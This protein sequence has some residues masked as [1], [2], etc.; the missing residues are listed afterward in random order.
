VAAALEMNKIAETLQQPSSSQ[1]VVD[2]LKA[3]FNDTQK[4]YEEFRDKAIGAQAKSV[5]LKGATE[6]QA[7]TE[8]EKIFKA[9][10]GEKM[11]GLD[12]VLAQAAEDLKK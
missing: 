3:K 2:E 11:E 5:V 8:L 6:A 4:R 10:A 9:K 7:R 1:S 12:A